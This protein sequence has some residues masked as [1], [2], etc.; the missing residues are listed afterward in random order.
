[1]R[2]LSSLLSLTSFG[3]LLDCGNTSPSDSATTGTT[4]MSS[5]P[6]SGQP[7]ATEP[8]GGSAG[9]TGSGGTQSTGSTSPSGSTSSTTDTT[10]A[11]S[12]SD[13]PCDVVTVQPVIPNVM[14]VLDKSG[15]MLT[16]WDHDADPNTPTVTRWFS[17]WAVVD[18][19]LTSSEQDFGFG[20]NLFP[21]TMAQQAYD[22]TACPVNANVEVK[23]AGNNKIAIEAAL[24]A[25]SNMTIAGGT[26]TAA[27]LNAALD[28]LKG[29]DPTIPRILVL[30]TDGA[31]N[32]GA[33]AMIPTELFEVYDANVPI[34][35]DSAYKND[36]IPTYV[37]G[38]ATRD[39]VTPNQQDGDPNG[40]NPH[41]KL[42]EL[43]T[44]GG[45]ARPGPENF[46]NADNQIEL[47]DALNAIVA[48]AVSCQINLTGEPIFPDT[49]K[50]KVGGAYVPKIEDCMTENGWTW[51]GM[52]P[53]YNRI[54]LCGTSCD[55]LKVTGQAVVE[56][57][58]CFGD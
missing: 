31:A 12:T 13:P 25:Q 29:L 48:D 8:P 7:T 16:L 10:A 44:L 21:S 23:V 5:M 40:I 38:I 14:L 53:P 18:Q 24:P 51:A 47:A 57:H 58:G 22:D 37:L 15:S 17:L 45:T 36:G 46:Y 55:Q 19:V 6:D 42:N 52:P 28:H 43:A 30:I 49:T 3:L 41:D 2:R 35:V 1:M 27:G 39:I 32:C 26:P 54:F 56:Y 50:V 4:T 33:N 34:I 20:M 11:S 9:T